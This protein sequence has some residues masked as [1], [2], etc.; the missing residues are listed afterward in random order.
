M[1]GIVLRVSHVF[2]FNPREPYGMNTVIMIT[3]LQIEDL[4]IKDNLPRVQPGSSGTGAQAKWLKRPH[5]KLNCIP[6]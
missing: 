6:S 2:S 5:L 4:G 1:P 3:K